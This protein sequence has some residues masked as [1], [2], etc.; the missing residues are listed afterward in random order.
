MGGTGARH[1]HVVID[2]DI[3]LRPSSSTF[4]LLET[5]AVGGQVFLFCFCFV[6]FWVGRSV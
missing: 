2:R 4:E 3:H 6:L 5:P 1:L